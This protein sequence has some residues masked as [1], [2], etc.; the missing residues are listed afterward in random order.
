MQF[1]GKKI[2]QSVFLNYMNDLV[3]KDTNIDLSY[4]EDKN[5][6]PL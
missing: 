6:M 3:D 1:K 5:V 4:F 2:N